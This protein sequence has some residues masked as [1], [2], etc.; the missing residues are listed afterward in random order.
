MVTYNFSGFFEDENTQPAPTALAPAA[1]Q[2]PTGVK[3][4]N[5]EHL[6]KKVVATRADLDVKRGNLDTAQKQFEYA[7][8]EHAK[9]Y[10]MLGNLVAANSKKQMNERLFKLRELTLESP[11]K[12]RR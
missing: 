10:R 11:T 1:A 2:T 8:K 9:Y 7:N 12:K 6:E 5:T 4:T 3:V